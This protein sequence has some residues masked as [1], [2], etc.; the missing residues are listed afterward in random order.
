MERLEFHQRIL[1]GAFGGLLLWLAASLL[2]IGQGVDD[3]FISNGN[4]TFNSGN[5]GMRY[6]AGTSDLGD[7]EVNYNEISERANTRGANTITI[8]KITAKEVSGLLRNENGSSN[9]APT[10]QTIEEYV[11]SVFGND[12]W[13]YINCLISCESSYRVDVYNP[14][15]Y[16]SLLQFDEMTYYSNGGTDIWDW[17]EMIRI[18]KRLYDKGELWRWPVCSRMCQ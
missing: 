2:A 15:G 10:R 16:Y 3:G 5:V 8:N 18:A 17:K 6:W 14:L 13:D 12:N 7:V 1:W 11:R 4:F 9:G